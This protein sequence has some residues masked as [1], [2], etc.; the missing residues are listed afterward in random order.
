MERIGIRELRQN[1]SKYLERVERGET[2]EVTNRGRLAAVLVPAPRPG[3]LA[4]LEAEGHVRRATKTVADLGPRIPI[5]P[6]EIA[7]SEMVSRMRDE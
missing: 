6:G 1:A 5:P 2:I 7:P 3:G 4:R